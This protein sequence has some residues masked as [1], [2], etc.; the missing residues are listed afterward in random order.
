MTACLPNRPGRA[1]VD[2]LIDAVRNAKSCLAAAEATDIGSP[3][4]SRAIAQLRAAV[5]VPRAV[6]DTIL[7]RG[8]A[9]PREAIVDLRACELAI[10]KLSSGSL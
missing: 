4:R 10:P 5:A 7:E 3:A 2:R 1:V 8:Q 9:V 6:V